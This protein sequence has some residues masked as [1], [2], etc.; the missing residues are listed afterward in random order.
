MDSFEKGFSSPPQSD[1]DVVLILIGVFH[2]NYLTADIWIAFG[3]GKYVTYT[4]L[5]SLREV[6]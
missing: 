3:T 5:L 6:F 4:I 1:T 2:E